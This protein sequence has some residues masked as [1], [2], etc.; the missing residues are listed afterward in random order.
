MVVLRNQWK[1]SKLFKTGGNFWK[2]ESIKH[3]YTHA[4]TYAHR[5]THMHEHMIAQTQTTSLN[6]PLYDDKNWKCSHSTISWFAIE[7]NSSQRSFL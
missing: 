7:K 5:F 6:K 1:L 3:T 4:H 2:N